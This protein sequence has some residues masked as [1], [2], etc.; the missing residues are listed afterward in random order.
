MPF[1]WRIFFSHPYLDPGITPNM[2][3]MLRV[4]PDQ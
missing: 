1:Q 2:F 3:F 4:T